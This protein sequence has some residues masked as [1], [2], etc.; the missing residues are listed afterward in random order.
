LTSQ[1]QDISLVHSFVHS[2]IG[3]FIGVQQVGSEHSHAR[4]SNSHISITNQHRTIINNHALVHHCSFV[5]PSTVAI[6][7]DD[8]SARCCQ[9]ATTKAAMPTSMASHMDKMDL[10]LAELATMNEGMD[11][12]N[13][14]MDRLKKRM[15]WNEATM[16]ELKTQVKDSKATM[17]E[18]KTQVKDSEAK[19][20][21][22]FDEL[23]ANTE[24]KFDELKAKTELKFDEL[25]NQIG[26]VENQ[27]GKV[28]N[29]LTEKL[30]W[31]PVIAI[32]APL[33]TSSL[34]KYIDGYFSNR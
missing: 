4:V 10:V 23:K 17:Q 31:V 15:G 2:F 9:P 8:H 19:T 30:Y 11:Q 16:R 24:L 7:H 18:L 22:K 12:L 26:K 34:G 28:E 5:V 13:K 21:L 25:K 3:S 6:P 1:L 14:G 32:V 20:E 29:Q 33:I 27:I